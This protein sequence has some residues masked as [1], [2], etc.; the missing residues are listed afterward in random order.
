MKAFLLSC[1]FLFSISLFAQKKEPSPIQIFD[2]KTGTGLN[3][4]GSNS[5][6]M[7]YT[8]ELS[9]NQK[10]LKSNKKFPL[11]V[12]LEPNADKVLIASLTV[13]NKKKGW[14][15]GSQFTY[16]PGNYQAVHDDTFAY[17][18]PYPV[19]EKYLMSQ[20]YNGPFSHAGK[21]ALDFTMP[22]GTKVHAA[23][24]GIVTEIKEDSN[25]GCANRDCVGLAN[26]IT[27]M[28]EDGSFADYVHLKKNGALVEVGDQV[29]RGDY[30]GLSGNTGFTSG[31]HLHFEVYMP[32][33]G[34]HKTIRTQFETAPGQKEHLK[35]KQYQAF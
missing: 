14:S 10:N 12:V 7:P 27:I 4:Y 33:P 32:A 6:I 13:D 20:G 18:L 17:A 21:N 31:P 29:K 3:I 24:G 1:T 19:G 35:K 11:K 25:R 34:N 5:S 2:E 23:R 8:M 22:E 15:Y 30:I 28:H 26:L 16:Y 9:V